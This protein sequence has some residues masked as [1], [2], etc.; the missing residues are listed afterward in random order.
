MYITEKSGGVLV[1]D[2]AIDLYKTFD[3]GQCFRF[4]AVGNETYKGVVSGR[5]VVVKATDGGFYVEGMDKQEFCADFASFFDINRNYDEIQSLLS[6]AGV[7]QAALDSGKGIH[8]LRQ[9]PWEALCSFIISQNNN[10]PRIKKIIAALCALLGD[11]ISE[12][13]YSFPTAEKIA[14]AGVDGLAPIRAGFRAKYLAD[15]A[16]KVAS[17]TLVLQDLYNVSLEEAVAALCTVKGVGPKV[18]SC[19]A[20]FGLGHL[21]AFP[22]D[23]WIKRVLDKYYDPSFSPTVFGEYAGIAQQYLFYH[24]RYISK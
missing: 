14:A 19:V 24:E 9:D 10:I 21:D 1:T 17:G 16:E 7:P 2:C 3:C 18:A 5:L 15:A 13:V 11:E 22:I 8:I 4:E 12:G 20:L 23:V 6:K